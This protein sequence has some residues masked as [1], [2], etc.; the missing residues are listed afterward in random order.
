MSIS[1]HSDQLSGAF[2]I[3]GN[4]NSP[5]NG[6]LAI[7]TCYFWTRI[8]LTRSNENVSSR[9]IKEEKLLNI[10]S[11]KKKTFSNRVFPINRFSVEVVI[12]SKISKE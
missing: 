4:R 7:S 12:F 2:L 11:K 10:I 5:Q 8:A 1:H 3:P 9:K 6:I